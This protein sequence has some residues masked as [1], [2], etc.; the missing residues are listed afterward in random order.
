[1]LNITFEAVRID[2]SI[3]RIPSE[4]MLAYTDVKRCRRC[5]SNSLG[6]WKWR[7]VEGQHLIPSWRPF[8]SELLLKLLRKARKRWSE[9]H[10]LIRWDVARQSPNLPVNVALFYSPRDIGT[11]SL[12]HCPTQLLATLRKFLHVK[13]TEAV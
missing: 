6:K 3:T 12:H 10:M 5:G 11:T 13:R 4:G 7:A 9:G 2:D 1:M 8:D